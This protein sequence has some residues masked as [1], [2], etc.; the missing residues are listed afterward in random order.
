MKK[1]LAI[2]V[3]GLLLVGSAYA[4]VKWP[5]FMTKEIPK[6][7]LNKIN[8]NSNNEIEDILKQVDTKNKQMRTMLMKTIVQTEKAKI[9][10]GNSELSIEEQ[11][12]I[13]KLFKKYV[14]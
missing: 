4:D 5:K 12:I 11:E 10:M 1:L 2:V 14:Q 7:I 9:L 13:E 3:L 6:E 8:E